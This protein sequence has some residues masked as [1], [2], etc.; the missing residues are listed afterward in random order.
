MGP[1]NVALVKLFLADQALKEAQARL[2]SASKNVRVQER[3]VNEISERLRLGQSKLKEEQ[4]HSH[5]YDL[6]IKSRD[7]KIDKLRQQQSNAQNHREYQA[8][9]VEINTEKVD[10]AKT[11]DLSIAVMEVVEKLQAENKEL[12]ASLE[13]E[14]AKL[15][16]MQSEV[17]DRL[18]KLQ[19]EIDALKPDRDAA[20]AAVPPKALVAFERL[21]DRFESEALS[22]LSKPDRRREEYLCSACNMGLVTDVY[23]KLHTRDELVFCPSCRRILYIP[24]DLPVETAVNIKVKKPEKKPESETSNT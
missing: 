3:R 1:T 6:D 24:D 13:S 17:G 12:A 8:F 23:N 11:E 15:V 21:A 16:S 2:E 14:K 10:K 19:A 5:N 7:E 20:A 22:A 18:K 9:L 4:A